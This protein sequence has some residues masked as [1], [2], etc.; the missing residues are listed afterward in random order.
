MMKRV[1]VMSCVC[2]CCAVH[3]VGCSLG[4]LE[5]LHHLFLPGCGRPLQGKTCS[6]VLYQKL[7]YSQLM[8]FSQEDS[9][10]YK[11]YCCVCVCVFSTS[12]ITCLYKSLRFWITRPCT[13]TVR[14]THTHTHVLGACVL[15][16][17]GLPCSPG[18]PLR[19]KC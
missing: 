12:F 17:P 18:A 5:C 16:S 1:V 6:H 8:S 11:Y 3:C 19:L 10:L 7:T 4:G 2:F 9:Y 15:V 13:L 14:Q